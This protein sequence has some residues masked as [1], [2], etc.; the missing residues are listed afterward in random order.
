MT[1]TIKKNKR[2]IIAKLNILG[3]LPQAI[4]KVKY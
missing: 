3:V 1:G 4:R 2:H